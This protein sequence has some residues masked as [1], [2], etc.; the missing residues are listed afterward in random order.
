MR[1]WVAR[2]ERAWIDGFATPFQG[3]PLVGS[4]FGYN[5]FNHFSLQN[6]ALFEKVGQ[7]S[8]NCR[9]FPCRIFGI[10]AHR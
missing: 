4:M 6:I 8:P 3:V 1:G 9:D 5:D 10:F 2:P 7:L